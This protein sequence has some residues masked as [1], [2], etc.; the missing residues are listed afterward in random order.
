MIDDEDD[1]G[2]ALIHTRIFT[3]CAEKKV[4]RGQRKIGDEWGATLYKRNKCTLF[5]TILSYSLLNTMCTDDDP[6]NEISTINLTYMCHSSVEKHCK[7]ENPSWTP[8]CI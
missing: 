4:Q 2:L 3:T 5:I 8:Y 7:R 6:V 1:D